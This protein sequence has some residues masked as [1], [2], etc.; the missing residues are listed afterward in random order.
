MA[1]AAGRVSPDKSGNWKLIHF[2]TLLFL[3][4]FNFLYLINLQDPGL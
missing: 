4:F 1:V 2:E 3:Y